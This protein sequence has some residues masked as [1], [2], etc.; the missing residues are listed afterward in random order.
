MFG[1]ERHTAGVHRFAAGDPISA[2][3]VLLWYSLSAIA[4]GGI[5]AAQYLGL[6]A[7][8]RRALASGGRPDYTAAASP[9]AW[10]LA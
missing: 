2:W 9:G 10:M 5:G 1:R 8:G 6:S 7:L 4:H 3:C